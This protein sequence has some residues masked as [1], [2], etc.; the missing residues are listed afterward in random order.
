MAGYLPNI[1]L[2]EA[3]RRLRSASGSGLEMSRQ[4]LAEAINAFLYHRHREL[5]RSGAP[6]CVDGHAIAA[7]ERGRHRWPGADLREAFR[8]VL[9]VAADADLGFHITRRRTATATGPAA[10]AWSPRD[11]GSL[12]RLRR[13]VHEGV[14]PAG[15]G[16]ADLDEWE[17]TVH[18]YGRRTRSSPAAVLLP[19]LAAGLNELGARLQGRHPASTQR[20]LTRATAQMA[21]LVFLTLIKLDQP[22]TA[23]AWART[24]R[25]AAD[26]AGDPGVHSWVRA[27]EAYVHF[28]GGDLPE[29]IAV[30]AHARELAGSTACVG[31]C[32]AAALQARAHAAL[33]QHRETRTALAAAETVLGRLDTASTTA[34]AFGYNEAQLRFHEGN[35]YTHLGT[36]RAATRARTRLWRCAR[37]LTTSTA[38]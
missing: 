15:T 38:P 33:G 10:G 23:R 24:A 17:R 12:E 26:E 27:Q 31:T 22:A 25:V 11:R 28:Y 6:P 5:G 14:S 4:E 1:Q 20:R 2:S 29:A 32:L 3:R 18:E 34:S 13:N 19:E 37:P 30:A 8:A 36:T 35:A 7:Y 21:G 9:G 16:R